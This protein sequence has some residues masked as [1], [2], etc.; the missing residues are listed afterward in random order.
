MNEKT[1]KKM[2]EQCVAGLGV[3]CGCYC[4]KHDKYTIVAD[5]REF[6]TRNSST[7]TFILF[8]VVSFV[9]L[10]FLFFTDLRHDIVINRILY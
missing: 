3:S 9:S 7:Y 1:K 8:I 4:P 10:V 6:D 2:L 5:H